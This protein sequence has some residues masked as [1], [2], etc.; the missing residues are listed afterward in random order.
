MQKNTNHVLLVYSNN[1]NKLKNFNT[2]NELYT[3]N[4]IHYINT[5]KDHN[6]FEY[7]FSTKCEKPLLYLENI[8][9]K[10]STLLFLLKTQNNINTISY[11]LFKQGQ[12][13][14]TKEIN[15][16]SINEKSKMEIK[17]SYEIMNYKTD[18]NVNI[19]IN[20][21]N[22]SLLKKKKING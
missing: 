18:E 12:H 7:T 3:K 9:K 5:N 10:N 4:D 15:E 21:K 17:L 20:E 1:E 13:I 16:F 11:D 14:F 19:L 6:R 22:N 2:N 8:S